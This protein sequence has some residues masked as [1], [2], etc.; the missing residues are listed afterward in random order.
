[1]GKGFLR[2]Q[3]VAAEGAILIDHATITITDENNNVLHVQTTDSSGHIPEISLDAPDI[4]LTEDPL[5]T[6]RRYSMYNASVSAAGYR[7]TVYRGVMIF[8]QSTSIQVINVRPL[9]RSDVQ[10]TETLEIGG[11]AL[12]E[13]VMPEPQD[14]AP[15][16]KVLKEVIIPNFI[17]V[18]LGR[19]ENYAPNVR[20]PFIDYIKNVA[21]HEIFDTWPEQTLVANIHCIV[22]LALNRI[23][24]EF[25]RKQGRSFD[26]TNNTSIDQKYTHG[27]T[28]GSRISAVVDRFFNSY[29]AQI[30]HREPFL[31]LY[32]DG[33][34]ANIPGRL[35]QWGSF[36]DARDR[37]MNAWQMIEKYFP[38]RLE[39]R[40]SDNFSG[41]LE[42]WPGVILS[43][44]SQGEYVRTMQRYLNRILGRYT[45][46]I[47]NPVDGIF[48]ASTRN[49]VVVFQQIYNLPPT[50]E[51]NRAT[52]YQI[53]RIYSIEKALWEMGSE[54]DRIGIG[55]TPPTQI[56]REGS[57]GALVTELQFI[58]DFVAMYHSE[59]PFVAET[60]RFDNLTTLA[61]REFQRMFGLSPDGIV[62]PLTWRRLYDVYWGIVNN[63]AP[64]M[65]MPPP[66]SPPG[67]PVYPGTILRLGSS[68]ESVRQ[69]QVAINRLADAYP[70]LWVIPESGV[71]DERTRDAILTF[72]RMFGL[73]VDGLVGPLT[74]ARLM[75]EYMDLQPGGP[76]A[77]P[78]PTI[79]PYPGF[80]IRQ[81][82][83]GESVRLVQQAI[84]RL[85]PFY[86]GRLWR[87]AE[88]GIFGPNTRDA[89]MSFQS[90]FGL[91]A[92]G[93]VGPLTWERLMRES[94]NPGGRT[95]PGEG[96]VEFASRAEATAEATAEAAAEAT[97]IAEATATPDTTGGTDQFAK[98]SPLIGILLA[99]RMMSRRVNPWC[100]RM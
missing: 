32:N 44:G 17:I 26:I 82:S 50:G 28:I 55:T 22:S 95:T 90:I 29:L 41:P 57:T 52:W 4:S 94:A 78:A 70:Q 11:H 24:T 30:G 35:S 46:I 65:P 6:Q 16:L 86:P 66:G 18:H 72:Q 19:P 20:V 23:F 89:V 88:D 69:I 84:N 48:G 61:V 79:P 9:S 73:S 93:V 87:I 47:I 58:L 64:P 1:M 33:V 98:I 7:H 51:I 38:Q 67:M 56:I 45:N 13:P 91:S 68:G 14:R 49:S 3:V 39:L 2:L 81:G 80:L 54:G 34:V 12:D 27:G 36:F 40:R 75:T 76:S 62:G 85:V 43:V 42:S 60:S 97:V 71:F 10:S 63:V 74:W 99:R 25:Y 21:S 5:T 92:D 31:S 83:T 8:D 37:G 15:D 53:S 77:P 100:R 96:Q 59:I